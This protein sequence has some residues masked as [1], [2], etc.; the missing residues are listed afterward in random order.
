MN[1]SNGGSWEQVEEKKGTIDRAATNAEEF[2]RWL[3][4]IAMD[5]ASEMRS[6]K[7]FSTE[8]E[9]RSVTEYWMVSIQ[10]VDPL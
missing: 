10:D 7:I 5:E 9:F 3:V 8:T 1:D 2:R 4:R 6:R